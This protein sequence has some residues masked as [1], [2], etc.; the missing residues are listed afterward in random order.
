M[1]YTPYNIQRKLR[2]GTFFE[3]VGQNNMKHILAILLISLLPVSKGPCQN[4]EE[5][6][7][8]IFPHCYSLVQYESIK[9]L[10]LGNLYYGK[11]LIQAEGDTVNLRLTNHKIVFARLRSIDNPNDSIEIRGKAKSGNWHFI[12]ENRTLIIDHISYLR[13]EK[14]GYKGCKMPIYNIP[15]RIK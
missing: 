2:R 4:P 13:I 7:D 1:F 11:L 15:V 14:T 10:S 3:V 12:D 8:P 6:V 9:P 5:L